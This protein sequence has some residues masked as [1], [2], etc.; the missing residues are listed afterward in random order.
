[1]SSQNNKLANVL[2]KYHGQQADFTFRPPGEWEDVGLR[3]VVSVSGDG[4]V[5][6]GAADIRE[7][8]DR[9]VCVIS[10]RRFD[11]SNFTVNLGNEMVMFRDG[12]VSSISGINISI[13]GQKMSG[14]DWFGF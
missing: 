6:I 13:Q 9:C 14:K 3:G 2:R 7:E 11:L 4:S 1:M 10:G 12:D 5:R 8:G